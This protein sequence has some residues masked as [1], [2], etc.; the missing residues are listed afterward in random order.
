MYN[1]Y[2]F[3]GNSYI[4]KKIGKQSY[5]LPNPRNLFKKVVYCYTPS[6][7]FK[8][9]KLRFRLH[10]FRKFFNTFR[11][12]IHN[13]SEHH[14]V[15]REI[16]KSSQRTM[17]HGR[18]MQQIDYNIDGEFSELSIHFARGFVENF[19]PHKYGC[20][21]FGS[22]RTYSETESDCESDEEAPPQ[23]LRKKQKVNASKPHNKST[24]KEANAMTE[25]KDFPHGWKYDIRQ[26]PS[27]RKYSL[28]FSPAGKRF[29]SARQARN[30]IKASS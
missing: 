13:N 15:L 29:E 7:F 25:Y 12:N 26:T 2:I 5:K 19:N 17:Q 8:D 3:G 22:E 30:Y 14:A 4:T 20:Q 16:E 23:P 1:G 18:R 27:G 9:G 24:G 6:K 21:T 28:F 10:D 11:E